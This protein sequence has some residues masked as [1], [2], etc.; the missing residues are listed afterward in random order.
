MS[1][2]E[3]AATPVSTTQGKDVVDDQT[4]QAVV[5]EYDSPFNLP[6]WRKWIITVLLA[7]MTTAVTFASSIWSAG[8]TK[9]SEQF[10]VSETVALLGVS[11]Y[12]LGFAVGPILWGKCAVYLDV[13]VFITVQA[14]QAEVV[15]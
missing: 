9:M 8:I 5:A 12:V 7:L 1:D 11:L 2:L 10:H 13:A 14:E 6:T 3:K 4:E 15:V